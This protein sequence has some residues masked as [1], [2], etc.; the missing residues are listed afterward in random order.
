MPIP[1]LQ[2]KQNFMLHYFIPNALFF[3]HIQKRKHIKHFYSFRSISQ[4]IRPGKFK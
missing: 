4:N 1:T 3:C 2:L